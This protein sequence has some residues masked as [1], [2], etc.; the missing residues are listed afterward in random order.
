MSLNPKER[1]LVDDQLV[2]QPNFLSGS[3]VQSLNFRQIQF[4]S[5]LVCLK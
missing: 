2:S 5:F 1:S 4:A 3:E